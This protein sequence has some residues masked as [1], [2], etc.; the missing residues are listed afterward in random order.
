MPSVRISEFHYDNSGTD[1]GEAIEISGPAGTDLTGWRIVRYNGTST[2]T[3]ATVYTSPGNPT[4]SGIIQQSCGTRGVVVI[5][6]PQDG[7]QNGA[8]D[9]FA[10][11]N[12]ANQVVEFL[13][14]E[15]VITAVS[16][17]STANPAGG[18]TSTDVGVSEPGNATGTSIKRDSLGVWS[19]S[20]PQSFGTC[21]DDNG[22]GPP[23][24]V[25]TSISVT[26]NPATISVGG[27]Q[28]FTATGF[29]A[30]NQPMT[31]L[32]FTWGT[33]DGSVATVN[34]TG[35][36]MGVAAGDADI[37]ATSG[38][39]VGSA[40]L[41]VSTAAPYNPPNIRFSEIHYDNVG[42]DVDEA[43]EIEGPVGT[44]L[45][46][47]SIQLYD[48]NTVGSFPQKVYSTTAVTGIL[49]S[50]PACN[51][52]GVISIPIAGI[53]NGSPDGFALVD[54]NGVLVEFLSYEGSF[55]AADGA[56]IGV[57]SRDI[58]VSEDNPVPA[59]GQSLH[60]SADGTTWN[61]PAPSD[62]GYVNACGAPPPSQFNV[63]FTGRSPTADPPLPV[64]FEGQ[65]FAT[66]K[67]GSTTVTTNFTWSS[68][69][70]AIA[71][72][73]QNGVFRS[74]TAGTAVIRATATDGTTGIISFPMVVGVQSSAPYG[75]NTEFGDPVDG[76]S[77]D[78]FIIRRAEYTTS[79]NKNLGR[80]NW[81][82]EKLDVTN[83]GSEDRCNCFTYDPELI[84]AG[85]TPYTTADYTGAGAFAGYGID[86]GHMTRSAD[87]TSGNLDNARTYYFSNVLPQ[88]AAVNQGPWAIE[89]NYLGDFAKTGGKTV[90]VISGGSGSKGTVKNEGKI[91]M[92]AYVWKVAVIMDHGKGLADVHSVNDLQVIAVIMPNDPV[93][94]SDWTTYKTTVDAVEALS[95][96][97]LLS[98]LP[99][100][101][102]N[103]VEG[104]D[105]P[106]VA[107]VTGSTSGNEGTALS[108]D[109]STSSDP[110]AGDVLSYS[111]TFG[112]GGTATGAMPT[113]T[114]ADNGNYTVTVTVTDSH[115]VYDTATLNVLIANVAPVITNFTA[116]SPTAAG[117]ATATVTFTDAGSAD[118]HTAVI[119]WGDGNTSTVNAG[120]AS[121][122]SA[123]HTYASAGF[124]TVGVT[125]TD[126]DGGSATGTAQQVVVYDAAAGYV[127]GGG[128][129]LGPGSALTARA[130]FSADVRYVGSATVPTGSFKITASPLIKD[131]TS[132]G[133]DY[134]VVNGNSGIFKGTG[135]LSNGTPV[136]FIV[137]GLDFHGGNA[138]KIRMK[139]WNSSTNAVLYD[140]QPGQAD[141]AAPTTFVRNGTYA[142]MH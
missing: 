77:S 68:D 22:A 93:I 86:R 55:T 122:A 92:P 87:R 110:D 140:T 83:Y 29:D 17:A 51:G 42:T 25:L 19:V 95:G 112:D 40:L 48:G 105:Q 126:D 11:V 2:P 113:H 47:W 62:M 65:V 79:F 43:I 36:A 135:T 6:Y 21:N 1:T 130:T 10:L 142:I 69:T 45:T 121:S 109:A 4:I 94:N 14:Y 100:N 12:A 8:S 125:V 111:W 5:N 117:A 98:L 18:T 133:F 54:Q 74:L 33:S 49:S 26:P 138:D 58:G 127:K 102:E 67:N 96:Y 30:N 60:R 50:T 132:S 90:Y 106:P 120:L 56:A 7:I 75:N 71:S 39:I 85:F 137:S 116:S 118:T 141:L 78:D 16:P 99:D 32:T 89:E 28:Q 61:P 123:T 37:S 72:V 128:L 104:N 107:R 34:S 80:P 88:A 97:D 82:S 76:N 66:E 103:A 27:T 24:Q 41:H 3:A 52:R 81:V 44:D 15:G 73:D 101:I 64:G 129:V 136:K 53:Q 20:S 59:I 46:G 119:T 108:F 57:T 13:S 38:T 124:Y 23:P 35:L 134:L 9:G 131:L 139:V 63:T 114:Y 31:G 84:A 115:G 70:P 91:D